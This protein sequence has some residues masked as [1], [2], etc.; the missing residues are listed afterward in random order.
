MTSLIRWNATPT[1]EL[2]GFRDDV[3]RLFRELRDLL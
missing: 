1:R 2:L 3:D